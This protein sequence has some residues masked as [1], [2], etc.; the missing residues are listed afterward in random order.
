MRPLTLRHDPVSRREFLW[1]AGL[2]ALGAGFSGCASMRADAGRRYGWDA[3]AALGPGPYHA[4]IWEP[5]GGHTTPIFV[6]VLLTGDA[7]GSIVEPYGVTDRGDVPDASG[8]AR[9]LR[10]RYPTLGPGD[11]EVEPLEVAGATIGY[12]VTTRNIRVYTDFDRSAGRYSIRLSG[13][14]K[15]PKRGGGGPGGAGGR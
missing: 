7:R 15:W 4:Q 3:V 6:V 13:L 10:E 5:I 8:I 11:V 14:G 12:V 1:W 2:A 9:E